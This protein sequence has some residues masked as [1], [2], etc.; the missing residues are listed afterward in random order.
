MTVNELICSLESLLEDYPD[1][2]DQPIYLPILDHSRKLANV[3]L[4]REYW[5]DGSQGVIT[6]NIYLSAY[7]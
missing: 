5:I 7:D 6:D 4:R 2:R 3:Q 1:L